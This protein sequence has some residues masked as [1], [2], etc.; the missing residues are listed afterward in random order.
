MKNALPDLRQP[1]G[2]DPALEDLK[3][4]LKAARSAGDQSLERRLRRTIQFRT[5]VETQRNTRQWWNALRLIGKR[6]ADMTRL[7]LEGQHRRADAMESMLG[8][9]DRFGRRGRL[10]TRKKQQDLIGRW[11]ATTRRDRLDWVVRRLTDQYP[12]V[13]SGSLLD[14]EKDVLVALRNK[15]EELRE[16]GQVEQALQLAARTPYRTVLFLP[17]RRPR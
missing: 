9:R 16:A 4:R 11:D 7:H 2:S 10:S 14:Q 15:V 6:W 3:Q 5:S 8:S 12:M 13:G 1:L 17:L